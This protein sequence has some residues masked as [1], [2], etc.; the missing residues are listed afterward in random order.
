MIIIL[1]FLFDSAFDEPEDDA[2]DV[3]ELPDW[4]LEVAEDLDVLIVERHFEDAYSL[5]EKTR[6]YLKESPPSNEIVVQDILYVIKL[7]SLSSI[8]SAD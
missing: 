7:I 3:E 6:N 5:I 1:F 8:F 4:L 2:D